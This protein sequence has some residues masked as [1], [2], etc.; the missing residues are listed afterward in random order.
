MN[1]DELTVDSTPPVAPSV[2]PLTSASNTPTVS[3]TASVGPGESLTV[4]ASGITYTAGTP[5]SGNALINNGDG[6][7]SFTV[8]SA[9]ADGNYEVTATVTDPAGNISSD[10]TSAELIVDTS[11][12]IQPTVESLNTSDTTPVLSGTA[13]VNARRELERHRRRVHLHRR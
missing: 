5:G 13:T 12:P 11:P 3:G 6:T 1:I 9:L 4:T 10:A 2:T 7:W 8:P